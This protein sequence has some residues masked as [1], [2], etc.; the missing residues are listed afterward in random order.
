M[1][2]GPPS[3]DS[4]DVVYEKGVTSHN[5]EV[6]G[7]GL[8]GHDYAGNQEQAED[9][10]PEIHWKCGTLLAL[11]NVILTPLYFRAY[12]VILSCAASYLSLVWVLVRLEVL[13]LRAGS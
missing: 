4:S 12:M 1:P 7:A 9:L 6:A 2:T 10:E 3:H 8:A 11:H 5:E 13:T